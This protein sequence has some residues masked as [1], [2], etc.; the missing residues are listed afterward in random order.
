MRDCGHDVPEMECDWCSG[1][2]DVIARNRP[3]PVSLVDRLRAARDAYPDIADLLDE[4]AEEITG[5]IE[6]GYGEDL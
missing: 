1:D 3:A 5:A 4:A 6:R 2:V